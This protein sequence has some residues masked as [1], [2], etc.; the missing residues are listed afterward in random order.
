M[1]EQRRL[2]PCDAA[3]NPPFRHLDTVSSLASLPGLGLPVHH[4]QHSSH[5]KRAGLAQKLLSAIF[6]KFPF[7]QPWF[8]NSGFCFFGFLFF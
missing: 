5:L 4:A 7:L 1:V 6:S 2:S 8:P 3:D